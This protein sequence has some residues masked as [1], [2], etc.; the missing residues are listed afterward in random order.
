MRNRN[1]RTPRGPA[2]EPVPDMVREA[3]FAILQHLV[4][5][6][7]VLD[8]FACS[9][10]LGIESLSRGSESVLFVE[11]DPVCVR[12][13]MENLEALDLSSRAQVITGDAFAALPA[14]IACG[15]RFNLAFLDPPYSVS[16]DPGGLK[17]LAGLVSSLYQGLILADQAMVVLRQ[18][19]GSGALFADAQGF[20]TDTRTYGSTQV[21]FIEKA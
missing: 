13:I 7:R 17:E 3:V 14:L 16:D 18:R 10:S 11:K 1:I 6:S 5:G 9:G 2:V 20:Q 4:P 12:T 15:H 21:A 8:M 19:K